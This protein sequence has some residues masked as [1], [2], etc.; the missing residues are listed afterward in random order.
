MNANNKPV[1]S[2]LLWHVGQQF[3]ASEAERARRRFAERRELAGQVLTTVHLHP[4]HQ[5]IVETAGLLDLRVEFDSTILP[6]HIWLVGIGQDTNP[7]EEAK[8]DAAAGDDN[9][10][11]GFCQR[12]PF[13]K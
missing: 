2:G 3:P 1:K 9:E 11:D 5:D 10:M 6:G 13:G 7:T 4:R 8:G 12:H